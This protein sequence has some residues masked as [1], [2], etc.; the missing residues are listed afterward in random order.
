MKDFIRGLSRRTVTRFFGTVYA[1]TLLFA[2][3]PPFYLASSGIRTPVFGIPF[4]ITYWILDAIVL[5][6]S[7]WAFYRVED[8]R[9]ELDENLP[10]AGPPLTGE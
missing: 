5:G 1:I 4:S 7:L 10:V 6:L 2:L 9:G 8:I 3:F